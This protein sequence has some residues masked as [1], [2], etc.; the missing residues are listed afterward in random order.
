[1]ERADPCAQSSQYLRT[2]DRFDQRRARYRDG[3]ARNACH[4]VAAYIWSA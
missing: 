2:R 1:M 4:I 3:E